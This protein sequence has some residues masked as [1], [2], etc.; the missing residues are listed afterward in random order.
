[1]RRV[2]AHVEPADLKETTHLVL[3]FG[4]RA[5]AAIDEQ[6]GRDL[7]HASVAGH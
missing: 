1:M 3:G 2:G 4:A 7:V 6:R 5:I